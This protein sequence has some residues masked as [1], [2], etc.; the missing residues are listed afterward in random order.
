MAVHAINSPNGPAGHDGELADE[1]DDAYSRRCS[2]GSKADEPK[3]LYENLEEHIHH[4]A[5]AF[6]V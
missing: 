3:G 5:D 6:D 2:C 4:Q 1:A